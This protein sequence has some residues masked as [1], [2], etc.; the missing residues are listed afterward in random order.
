[1]S[2]ELRRWGIRLELVGHKRGEV[3][4]QSCELSQGTARDCIV[5]QAARK[6]LPNDVVIEMEDPRRK[7]LRMTW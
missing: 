2:L 3:C 6:A 4:P 7:S 5:G 1:M